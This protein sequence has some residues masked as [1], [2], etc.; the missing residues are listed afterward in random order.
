L[1]FLIE[2]SSQQVRNISIN[3]N[4][5]RGNSNIPTKG[6]KPKSKAKRVFNKRQAQRKSKSK[7]TAKI[8]GVSHTFSKDV[9]NVNQV[10]VFN[11]LK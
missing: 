3:F 2:T 9:A 10:R 1:T 6:L 5:F 11:Y 8:F 4:E 7:V